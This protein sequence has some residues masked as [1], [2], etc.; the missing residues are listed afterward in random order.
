MEVH[1]RFS[2]LT[3]T[4]LFSLCV[5]AGCSKDEK[6]A[7]IGARAP[8]A[9]RPSPDTPDGAVLTMMDGLKHDHLEA[10]WEFLPASY[11][12]DLNELVHAFAERMDPEIW[13]STIGVL[14]KLA[15]LLKAQQAFLPR[16]AGP[17]Q[18]A[19]DW[20]KLAEMLDTVLESDLA[21]LK[22]LKNADA[23]KIMAVTGGRILG[24]LR[25]FSKL[26]KDDSFSN[27]IDRLA[28]LK[29]NLI[30]S[31]GESAT[32]TF[33]A[34][35]EEPT[36]TEFVRVEGK[37]IPQDLATEWVDKIGLYRAQLS[38]TLSAES[39]AEN[40]PKYLELLAL[41][42][43][44]FDKL[45]A[46]KTQADF[47]TALQ[48]AVPALIPKIAF[49]AGLPPAESSDNVGDDSGVQGAVEI[50]TVVVKGMLEIDAQ[51]DLRDKLRALADKGHKSEAEITSDDETTTI[52][53]GPVSDFAEFAKRLDF[54][55]VTDLDS[56]NR[57]ITAEPK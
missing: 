30:R 1:T 53:V 5:C 48:Q 40:K 9:T 27:T 21:D 57:I 15:K 28:D 8:A 13:S 51:D 19:T 11:H 32:L 6:P 52:K 56:K 14:R 33:E 54:L 55:K 38:T 24:Q 29:V 46:A 4:V 49:L 25:A 43:G 26:M 17:G 35:G 16:P 44:V 41:V 47:D 12:K 20:G 36:E 23:G 10:F 3:L 37:W 39:F 45:L 31:S 22:R 2:S 7:G 50:V 18:P 34:A 42:N